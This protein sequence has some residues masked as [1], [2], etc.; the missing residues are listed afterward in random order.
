MTV[1]LDKKIEAAKIV[2]TKRNLLTPPQVDVAL[3]IDI[4]GSMQTD[5]TRGVVQEITERCLALAMNF[6]VDKKLDVWTFS[7]G[8]QYVGEVTEK[9]FDGY[10]Q[11]E[12][13]NNSRITKW[14]GTNYAP[15]L[16]LVRDKFFGNTGGGI[17][18]FFKKK[19]NTPVFLMFITD[20]DN[21]D[22]DEFEKTLVQYRSEKVYVQM[23]CIGN[24]DFSYA[25]RVADAEPNV[26]FCKIGA[27]SALSDEQMMEKLIGEEFVSWAKSL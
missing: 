23:I 17:M 7:T 1:S 22:H 3:A 11:R 10:V 12:I 9:Q 25:E 14:G 5:Y 21:F 15:V 13:L 6:D 16:K 19:N 18:S 27:V 20:G 2:L 24:D 8:A 4:S 26:G